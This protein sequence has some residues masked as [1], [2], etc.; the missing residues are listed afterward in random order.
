MTQNKS[1][2][3]VKKVFKITGWFILGILIL[4]IGLRLSLK[5]SFVHNFVKNKAVEI[6]SSFLQPNLSIG[7]IQGDL[8]NEVE[9]TNVQIGDKNTIAHVDTLYATYNLLSI[10]SGSFIVNQL[11]VIK[12]D[13]NIREVRMTE[14]TSVV[15][16]VQEMIIPDTT[17]ESSTFGFS[18]E[19]ILMSNSSISMLSKSLLPDSTIAL[20]EI[21]MMGAFK[22][23][24]EIEGS[25]TKLNF[26][27]QEGRLP[28]NIAFNASAEYKNE[29]VTLQDLVINT[30]KSML[31][32]NGFADVKDT[33]VNVNADFRPL[34]FADIKPYLEAEIA[35]EEIELAIQ[36]KGNAK[37]IEIKLTGEGSFIDDVEAIAN[38]RLSNNP[39]LTSFGLKGKNLDIAKLTN[40]S[41]K[42]KT[43]AFQITA[44]GTIGADYEK[45]DLTW[46]FD[47]E[48]IQ[49]QDYTF[50]KLFGSGTLVEG[51]ILANIEAVSPYNEKVVTLASVKNVFDET[52][53]WEFGFN[54][55]NLNAENWAKDAPNTNISL[56][57]FAAGIGFT[58]SEKTWEYAISNTIIDSRITDF[59]KDFMRG[60]AFG[61]T[62]EIKIAADT[63][64]QF[65]VVGSLNKETLQTTASVKLI[66][67]EIK[68][69][70]TAANYLDE[71]PSYEYKVAISKLNASSFSITK[72]FPTSIN[73][74]I[75]GT[76]SGLDMTSLVLNG[77]AKVD[78]SYI[79]GAQ[80][81]LI[82]QTY[83]LDKG[84]LVITDAEIK[85]EIADA[86]FNG[87]KNLMDEKDPDNILSFDLDI[88]NTQPFASLAE[89][90][91]L[92][93]SG[94]L[95]ADIK[96]N[97]N[98]FLE[99]YAKLDL[100]DIIIDD[101]LVADGISGNADAIIKQKTE[102][103]FELEIFK[104]EIYGTK[105]QDILFTTQ[106]V[107]TEDSLYG[108]YSIVI[109]D[110]EEGKIENAGDYEV[111][112]DSMH[113]ALSMDKLTMLAE[114][115]GLNLQNTFNIS[116]KN[117]VLRTD[118]LEL[119]SLN[120][121]FLSLS[122]PYADSLK[123]NVWF[124]GESFDF[125]ILQEIIFDEKYIDGVLNGNVTLNKTESKLEGN[126]KLE[127]QNIFYKGA[128]A[129][130]LSIEFDAANNRLVSR[131][132]MIWDKVEYITGKVDV[133]LDFSDPETL[134]D[135]FF[136]QKVSGNITVK[137]IELSRFKQVLNNFGITGT[138][139][140]ISFSS[141]L[142][143]T[144][145]KPNLDGAL[146]ILNPKLSD[147][148]LD[149]VIA[150][151]DY[152]QENENIIIA[153][154]LRAAKQKAADV[155]INFPFS[156]DF[157]T[158]EVKTV[159]Q[160]KPVSATIKT[161][162]FNLAV[163][164]DFLDKDLTKNLKG[165][166]NGML[167]LEGTENKIT[168]EGFF[169]LTNSSVEVP[170]LGIKI[171]DIRSNIEFEDGK[172]VLKELKAKSG[173]GEFSMMGDINLDGLYPTNIDM[174]AKANQFKAA[175]TSDYNLVVDLNSKLTGPISTPKATGELSVKNG[176]IV[177]DNFGDK[178][179]EEVQLEGEERKP[180]SMYDS[181]A[182]DMEFAIERNFFVRNRRYLDMEIEIS[183]RLD[184][185]KETK[186]ELSL[187][188]SLSGDGGYLRPLGKRFELDEAE[189]SFSGPAANPDLNIRSSYIPLSRKGE[190]EVTLYY[191]IK[192]T[193]DD[194]KFSFESN[195]TMEKQDIVCYT[196]FNRPCYALD[197]WQNA[198]TSQGGSSPT[199]LLAGALI[200]E[201]ETLA[202][203]ELGVDV[204]QIDNTRVGNETGT[205]IKTGWYL[206]DRTFFAI[207]NEITS[208]DPKTL[209]I[210]E[211]A[212]SKTWD[213]IITEGEDQNQRGLDF[214]W[215]LDY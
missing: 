68:A 174:E 147:V 100:Q 175:N 19:E 128:E 132:G 27:I 144:A 38:V 186:G 47:F 145:G 137:P 89:L 139:G 57:G 131:L 110:D 136:N 30:G 143:G 184:A 6:A 104:P 170:I 134:S 157:K 126:G 192:G 77:S 191:I 158:F 199:D 153:A 31:Q 196:V 94:S 66:E 7:S 168:A 102:G 213:L 169:N 8:W 203:R 129:D 165:S 166:L 98:G 178:S 1:K 135:E 163:F 197:S 167:D 182:I 74:N 111:L 141:S 9:L 49:Y 48:Q 206:N 95:S 190:Q 146:K 160:N 107:T 179:V 46:G 187:F 177:L 76:G 33:L 183:G 51:N 40:D 106:S 130:I 82:K 14:D 140:L 207:V 91:I 29:T 22:M 161:S 61:E 195:P 11:K 52:P 202:T 60:L 35:N 193:V 96:E 173:K 28:Q 25:L 26:Q 164:N 212:L 24:E 44:D 56:N 118:S 21:E 159:G 149:S 108:R 162:D 152:S 67:G 172:I 23:D 58:P 127:L 119:T 188:G 185:L 4:I 18:I 53:K 156:Y 79:N 17:S 99:C 155:D 97:E 117:G 214:R 92:Q 86:A 10:F 211:Y 83:S 103:N 122:I 64:P 113:L 13:I 69:D 12:A 142:S 71:I 189:V 121:A 75:K 5:S 78:T 65:T 151:F 210:L 150:S 116:Y 20:K 16:N 138:D 109:Q 200:D 42:V 114:Q 215:Q 80:I 15:L 50:Q 54:L 45:A 32:V 85:S 180:V 154:E 41:V 59:R 125:G 2:H 123:Q 209:F 115:G 133:P 55:K 63:I 124:V 90:N 70:I 34:S 87:R 93:I 171:D 148:P 73:L 198:L 81:Q 204:V 112:L 176:F 43:R 62:K 101:M 201:I 120:G 39:Q 3:I 194:P 105:F 37:N 84:I 181:L 36:L 208:S 88:K 205:T 72:N